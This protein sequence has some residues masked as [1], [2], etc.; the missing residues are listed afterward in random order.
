MPSRLGSESLERLSYRVRQPRLLSRVVV[1]A[2]DASLAFGH[3][4]TQLVTHDAVHDGEA[5]LGQFGDAHADLHGVG[6]PDRQAK[7]AARSRQNRPNAIR[8]PLSE[9]A[10]SPEQCHAPGLEPAEIN[11]VVDVLER[12]E[13]PPSHGDCDVHRQVRQQGG[14]G[15]RVGHRESRTAAKASAPAK[16]AS[17]HIFMQAFV[18]REREDGCATYPIVE[19]AFAGVASSRQH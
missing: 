18:T 11:G 1:E 19:E 9:P 3:H 5:I 6:E 16:G 12:V 10:D 2:H 17:Q 14:V 4:R 15:G 13:V 7:Y 8:A